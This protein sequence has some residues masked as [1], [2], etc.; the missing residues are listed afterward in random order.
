IE[1]VELIEGPMS[2]IYGADALGGVINIITKKPKSE[3][4]SVGVRLHEEIVGKEYGFDRGIHNQ[5]LN[6]SGSYKNWYVSGGIGRN[7]F[8]GWKDS[9][10]G[11]EL[12]WHK[13]KQIVR[14]S[15]LGYRKTKLNVYYRC[16]G[17]DEIITNPANP[18]GS[19]PAID[20]DYMTD[21]GMH[22]VQAAYV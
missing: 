10:I 2:V 4:Y 9:A 6:A 21:R 22:Q 1:R 17:L 16:D 13:K 12:L 19:Q 11:R 18:T 7:L 15:I 20:Q 3:Q 14:K 5:Y 8:S